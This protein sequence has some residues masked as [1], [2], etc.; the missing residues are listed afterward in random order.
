METRPT[1]IYI[2]NTSFETVRTLLALMLIYY[3]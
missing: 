2:P 3:R 1:N